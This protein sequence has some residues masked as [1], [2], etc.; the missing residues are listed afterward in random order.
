[1]NTTQGT[2]PFVVSLADGT[3]LQATFTVVKNKKNREKRSTDDGM[4]VMGLPAVPDS[5]I[6]HRYTLDEN[7]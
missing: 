1:M 6:I 5:G 4:G 3:T 7:S 2:W